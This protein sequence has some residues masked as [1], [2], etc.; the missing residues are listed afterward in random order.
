MEG[1]RKLRPV[2]NE[3]H[4]EVGFALVAGDVEGRRPAGGGRLVEGEKEVCDLDLGGFRGVLAGGRASGRRSGLVVEDRREV[5]RFVLV[6]YLAP[7][8]AGVGRA[9]R[10]EDERVV[11]I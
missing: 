8:V 4:G 3:P 10:V 1:G 7:E 2:K 5:R 6:E 9:A 11:G